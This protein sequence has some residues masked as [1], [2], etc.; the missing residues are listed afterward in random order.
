MLRA[1]SLAT[2][3]NSA[4]A[5]NLPL[6]RFDLVFRPA[7]AQAASVTYDFGYRMEKGT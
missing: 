2:A 3:A 4:A 1:V 5:L 7:A 6:P